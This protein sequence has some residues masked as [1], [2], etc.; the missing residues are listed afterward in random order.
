MV[1]VA[2]GV[3]VALLAAGFFSPSAK[4]LPRERQSR[5]V[6]EPQPS[7]AERAYLLVNGF[8]AAQAIRAAVGLRI[9]D[10]VAAGTAT[11]A[12]LARE[13]G[14][15]QGRMLRFLRAL[16]SLGTL[17]ESP[18]RGYSNTAVGEQFVEEGRGLARAQ[19]L[20]LLPDSYAS[21]G[22]FEETMRTGRTGQSLAY[23]E[24]RWQSLDRDA[25]SAH[26][27]NQVMVVQSERVAAML[28]AEIDFAGVRVVVDV[29]GGNGA[30]TAGVLLAHRHVQGIVCD[31][32]AGLSGAAAYLDGR[33]LAGR[34]R[35]VEA[36]FFKS[37]PPGDLYLLKNII[38]DWDDERAAAIL[39]TCRRSIDAGGRIVLVERPLPARAGTGAN[40]L[41]L[42]MLDLQIMVE[43]GGRERTLDEYRDLL[44]GAGFTFLRVV[45]GEVF[46]LI[47]AEAR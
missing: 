1:A 35:L 30:L 10:H 41:S 18:E 40:D 17:E 26:A 46:S 3:S 37:V 6:S 19:A 20:M 12:E 38:H 42:A 27:F 28:A 2:P 23:G 16:V 9:F 29:G 25:A 43:L 15:D 7:P 24:D 21:W 32:A 36:D 13:T 47:E 4:Q 22:H 45:A 33:G 8:R 44:A 5:A 11:T 39:E 31:L 14:V 34:Y